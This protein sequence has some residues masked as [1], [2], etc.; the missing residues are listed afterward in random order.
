MVIKRKRHIF[1]PEM[2]NAEPWD[3]SITDLVKL[4]FFFCICICSHN[5]RLVGEKLL[6]MFEIWGLLKIMRKKP[7]KYKHKRKLL[8]LTQLLSHCIYS[9][10]QFT[11][12]IVGTQHFY[13]DLQTDYSKWVFQLPPLIELR[14]WNVIV[15]GVQLVK[16]IYLYS[17]F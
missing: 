9:A 8:P 13:V 2:L 14:T 15:S 10:R 1:S 6:I 16:Y 7:S 4:F 12:M 5:L 3:G 11:A 17:K